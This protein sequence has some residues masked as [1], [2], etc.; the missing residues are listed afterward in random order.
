MCFGS[1]EYPWDDREALRAA[2]R[3]TPLLTLPTAELKARDS[4]LL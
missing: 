1:I 3:G 2:L 4:G